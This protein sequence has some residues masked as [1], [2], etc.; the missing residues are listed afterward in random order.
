MAKD[1]LIPSVFKKVNPLTG[2]PTKNLMILCFLIA[3]VASFTPI[4]KLAD[5]TSFG[6]LFAFTMVCIAVW[7]LRK[8]EP[9]LPRNFKVPALPVIASLGIVINIYL[10][11]NLSIGAQLLSVSW[12]GIGVLIY[13][14]YSRRNSKLHNN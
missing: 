13:F 10:M 11:L 1:G 4:N 9:D 14:L 2:V 8:K 7:I 12:L 6:T 5:M 3:S